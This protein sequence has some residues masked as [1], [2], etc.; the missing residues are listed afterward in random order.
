MI[1][2]VTA[3]P[4]NMIFRV[5]E[6]NTTCPKSRS[7]EITIQGKNKILIRLLALIKNVTPSLFYAGSLFSSFETYQSSSKVSGSVARI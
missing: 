2:L 3:E 7:A 5:E 6:L 4:Q 1:N